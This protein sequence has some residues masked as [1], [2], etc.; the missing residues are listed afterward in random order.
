MNLP[1]SLGFSSILHGTALAAIVFVPV[2]LGVV[3]HAE[4]EARPLVRVEQTEFVPA[5]AF[6]EPAPT[7]EVIEEP[8]PE[9]AVVEEE[10][11]V[12]AVEPT[13][14]PVRRERPRQRETLAEAQPVIE[15]GD[16]PVARSVAQPVEQEDVPEDTAPA[17]AFAVATA[18]DAHNEN[19][20][21]ALPGDDAV[22]FAAPAEPAAAQP[23]EQEAAPALPAAPAIDVDALYAG[24]AASLERLIERHKSY[25]RVAQRAGLQGTVVL[26]VMIDHDGNVREV[27]I[28]QSSGHGVL[29]RAAVASIERIGRFN[30]PPREVPWDNRPIEIP[31][32]YI[33]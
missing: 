21:E 9:P 22:A 10:V 13:P 7:P 16:A 32:E 27:R 19:A 8:A 29:D 28:L 11:V 1:A 30:A 20:S 6:F 23:R 31:M 26:Q 2:A 17:E 4:D 18:H 33:L 12:A 25:P 14:P 15:G 24:Y 3:D 5:I